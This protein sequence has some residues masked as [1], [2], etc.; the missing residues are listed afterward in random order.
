LCPD[1]WAQYKTLPQNKA[2][3]LPAKY[4]F[5]QLI[6]WH[7]RLGREILGLSGV[8]MTDVDDA[9]NRLLVGVE[10]SKARAWVEKEVEALDIPDEAV[11][12][13]KTGPITFAESIRDRHRDPLAGGLLIQS[14]EGFFCTLGFIAER[15]QGQNGEDVEGFVTNSHCS[16]KI[17]TLDDTVYGQPFG[18]VS[19]VPGG[20]II[21]RETVGP[22]ASRCTFHIRSFATLDEGVPENG[23]GY[24]AR[25]TELTQRRTLVPEPVRGHLH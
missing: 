6:R 12:I 25:P 24:I 14:N 17:A 15:G 23:L 9:E 4:S 18:I 1:F 21:G 20:D 11:N 19:P 16:E 5:L 10:N 22:S 8:T 13:V 7:N 3:A 2:K